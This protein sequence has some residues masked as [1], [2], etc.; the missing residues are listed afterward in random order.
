M[1]TTHKLPLQAK[2]DIKGI[3]ATDQFQ[4]SNAVALPSKKQKLKVM[5]HMD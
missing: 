3:D 4:G 5:R 2:I 1:T